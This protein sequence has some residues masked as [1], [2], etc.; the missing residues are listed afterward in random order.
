MIRIEKKDVIWNYI[1]HFFSVAGGFMVLPFVLK[2]MGTEEIALYYI[3]LAV[4]SFV[5]LVDFGFSAQFHR[6][7]SYVFS[8]AE[9]LKKEGIGEYNT[10]GK[11]NYRLLS[12]IVKLTKKTYLYLALFAFLLMISVGT[13]YIYKVTQGFD[14]IDNIL[15]VWVLFS[16]S[17]V[18]NIYYEHYNIILIGKGCIQEAKKATVVSKIL[19]IILS[20]IFLFLGLGLF[21]IVLSNFIAPFANRWLAYNYLFTKEFKQKINIPIERKNILEMFGI[22]WYNTKKVGLSIAAIFVTT[23]F[24]IFLV[25]LYLPKSE[26][27]SYG[28]AIQVV[29]IIS[30]VATTFFSTYQP[31]YAKYRLEN[32]KESLLKVFALGIYVF[33][34]IFSVGSLSFLLLGDFFLGYIKSNASLPSM[35]ILVLLLVVTFFNNLQILFC[36]FIF[37]ENKLP[38]INSMII[39]SVFILIGS[40]FVLKY[41][42]LGVLGL[43]LVQGV[44][45]SVYSN[46]RWI[47][48]VL[49]DL[50][51]SLRGFIVTGNNEVLRKVKNKYL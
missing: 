45:E 24:S 21:G 8:G 50:G 41:T 19:S 4:A 15:Y 18:L 38:Y 51:V 27:A 14:L 23:K 5:Q 40:F 46:W 34:M 20:I 49:K 11:I 28:L 12:V 26:V 37:S 47:H 16:V 32:N 9:K 48:F 1:G 13:F 10:N 35:G 44:C 43:I 6:N 29:G 42:N 2:K 25:G 31:I 3:F 39:T 22:I 33:V 30:M 36:S 7:I 17:T